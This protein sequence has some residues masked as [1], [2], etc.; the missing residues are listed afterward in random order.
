MK[1]R[2]KPS[3]SGPDP[4]QDEDHPRP[5]A[6]VPAGRSP[7]T[8]AS[9]RKLT[10]IETARS[11]P[12]APRRGRSVAHPD[13]ECG[14]G[15]HLLFDGYGCPEAR[16]SDLDSLYSLLEGLPDRIGMTR[17]MPPYVFRHGAHGQP[18]GGLS[19]FVLIAESHISVHSFPGLGFVNA[20]VFSCEHFDA[21]EVVDA[22][23]E[24]FHP[25]RADWTLL[26][27]GREVPT[28]IG[29]SREAVLRERWA[30]ASNLGLGASR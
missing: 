19:G 8:R 3:A 30:L 28:S 12:I 6:A 21:T 24:A 2:S 16:L 5:L 4:D 14:F 7:A 15:P 20:D 18:G 25:E 10:T 13:A 9:R 11:G 23:R 1:A 17:I 26:D 22:L 27:R 29:Q